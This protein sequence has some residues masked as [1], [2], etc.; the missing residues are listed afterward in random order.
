MPTEITMPQL[1][2]TMEYGTIVNWLINEGDEVLVGQEICEI[3]TDKATIGVEA[4]H[5]GIVGRLLASVDQVVPVGAPICILVGPG[6]KLPPN[7]QPALMLPAT[8]VSA[9][10]K[11]SSDSLTSATSKVVHVHTNAPVQASWKAR[12]LARDLGLDLTRI[13]G[14]GAD[15]RVVAADVLNR[16]TESVIP[17]GD[18][19]IKSSPLALSLAEAL[20]VE[21]SQVRGTGLNGR[22]VREDV[23]RFAA[24]VISAVRQQ[25]DRCAEPVSPPRIVPLESVHGIV[26]QR[27][28]E[29]AHTT[30]RVTLI[31][32]AD[33]SALVAVRGRLKNQDI[34]VA[35]N[36]LLITMCAVALREHPEAN[37]RLTERGIEMLQEVHIGL[38]VDTDRGLLVPVIHHAHRLSLIE[39]TTESL[40]LIDE[41][42]SGRISPDDLTGGTFTLTSLGMY[43]VDAFTPV[44]NL[45]ECCILGVGRI[46]RKPIVDQHTDAVVVRPRIT[47]SLVFDHRVIDGASAARFFNRVVELVEEP[48]LLLPLSKAI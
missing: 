1:G 47:L 38:A 42:R 23:I 11:S 43:G 21:L 19:E 26:S 13:A 41:A 8:E 33:A 6:E 16:K 44:I 31:R 5:C 9:A 12:I 36:D 17:A 22:V 3:E 40:R 34:Q 25:I 7:W 46:I 28:A 14:T 20:G 27:M 2:L 15:G 30:A 18:H 37:A 45:P 32:E 48:M 29:S 24:G 10:P 35:Y 4:H 39:I